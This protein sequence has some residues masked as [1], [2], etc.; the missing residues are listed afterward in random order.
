M[1]NRLRL[2]APSQAERGTDTGQGAAIRLDGNSTDIK[3]TETS[4]N[5]EMISTKT[6]L[7]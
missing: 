4:V 2:A 1:K 7:G 6:P 3:H 5:E